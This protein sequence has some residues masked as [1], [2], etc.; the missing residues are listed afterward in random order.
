M[1]VQFN[2]FAS[3]PK[4]SS[5]PGDLAHA[6]AFRLGGVK[7]IPAER[8]IA[9]ASG[10][11]VMLEP[12][13][14]KVLV[15]LARVPGQTLSREDLIEECWGRRFVGDDAINRVVSR[16][17]S[18]LARVGEN[19]LSIMTIP[20]VGYRL[21]VGED[22]SG[23]PTDQAPP[24]EMHASSRGIGKWP[25]ALLTVVALAAIGAALL[26]PPSSGVA[27][28]VTPNSHDP[29]DAHNS[30]F[31]SD[32][33]TDLAQLTGSLTRLTLVDGEM[34]NKANMTLQVSLER[35]ADDETV[36]MRLVD[37]AKG[38]VIWSRVIE[39]SGTSEQA[40][41]ER[42]SHM[43]AGI[44]RCGLDKSAGDL[45]DPV[46][47][48]LYFSACDAVQSR[49][50][51]AARSFAQQIA[52][53][54]PD[55]AASWACL[56][57][58]TINS[59]SAAPTSRE[60]VA[61]LSM[62]YARKALLI[63]PRSGLAHQALA[64]SL[65]A[66]GKSGFAEI[67]Q[68]VKLDPEHSGLLTFYSL[69]L[70]HHGYIA[71]AVDPALRAMT[72]DPGDSFPAFTSFY[73]LLGAGKITEARSLLGKIAQRWPSEPGVLTL[74]NE[75]LFYDADPVP[76]RAHYRPPANQS[77][78]SATLQR[79]LLAW[80]ADPKAF[81]WHRFD[82]DADE[83]AGSEPSA[84]WNLAF[85]AIRMGDE[86]RAFAWLGNSHAVQ[87]DQSWFL[88]FWPEAA[89]LRRD[90]RFFAKMAEIGL[91]AEWERRGRWP[92]FCKDPG[93]RYNCQAEARRLLMATT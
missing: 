7:I 20:R 23:A 35:V 68:G 43:I 22:V 24:A 28:A 19:R 51:P 8:S 73:A 57:M 63:D 53:F 16:L 88:L 30:A 36:K 47:K 89:P 48:R 78:A 75:L 81:D 77:V 2:Q 82:R 67:E 71:A 21:E 64:M 91:V 9:V 5:R 87:G 49:D 83:Y 39:S 32:L 59:A 65:V 50:W 3:E 46:S 79:D 72:L 58:T 11:R 54:R 4:H 45:G 15:S 33:T 93:L 55:S 56:A 66:Q 13:V 92:D 25:T 60:T 42:A 52:E 40:L 62:R 14:M 76:A 90:P 26:A 80:R 74:E 6:A 61:A 41:R 84:A 31:A 69:A 12:L 17:R 44:I 70:D 38:A 34:P 27:I 86:H 37:T 18:Q 1:N 10:T 29:S 85:S